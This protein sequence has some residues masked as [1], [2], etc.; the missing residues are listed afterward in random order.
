MKQ[1]TLNIKT[2]LEND[3]VNTGETITYTG[4]AGIDTLGIV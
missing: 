1:I 3:T 4:G 2:Y